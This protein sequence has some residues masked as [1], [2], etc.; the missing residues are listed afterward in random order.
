MSGEFLLSF[1]APVCGAA[2]GAKAAERAGTAV[3]VSGK[4]AA[5]G[6]MSPVRPPPRDFS[7]TKCRLRFILGLGTLSEKE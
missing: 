3:P 7:L 1:I 5:G 4:P 2:A 6:G